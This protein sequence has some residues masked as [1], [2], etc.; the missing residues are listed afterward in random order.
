MN[1]P[2]SFSARCAIP[3]WES[4][5]AVGCSPRNWPTHLETRRVDCSFGMAEPI[6]TTPRKFWLG[7]APTNEILLEPYRPTRLVGLSSTAS[8]GSRTARYEA[9]R[10]DEFW[11]PALTTAAR[12]RHSLRRSY[13]RHSATSPPHSPI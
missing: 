8:L 7:L 9:T 5:W 10:P 2:A 6:R 3:R 11:G 12:S 13:S 4:K 1:S